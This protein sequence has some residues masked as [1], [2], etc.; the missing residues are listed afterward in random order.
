MTGRRAALLASILAAACSDEGPPLGGVPE[1][2]GC[3]GVIEEF[4]EGP[5]PDFAASVAEVMR[6]ANTGRCYIAESGTCGQLRYTMHSTGFFGFTAWFTASGQLL[7]A[8]RFE[9]TPAFCNGTSYD[10]YFGS[11]PTCV[12]QV[13]A[14]Y[15]PTQ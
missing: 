6:L 10:E 2:G 11:V 14:H 5:C 9:D 4:C 3:V 13:A 7:A 12:R 1:D 8:F 15:C